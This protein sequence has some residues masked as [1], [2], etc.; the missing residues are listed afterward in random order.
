MATLSSHTLNSTNGTHA[1]GIEVSLR[2][3]NTGGVLFATRM[4]SGGRL[5]E[6]IDISAMSSDDRYE[7]VFLTAA[8]WVEQG[9]SHAHIVDEIV[10]RFTMP[11]PEARYHMPVIL[12]PNGY[13]MWSSIPEYG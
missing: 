4:D 5:A 9:V 11:D 6:T 7:L 2:N 13:S 8:Y 1:G 3:I 10:L 12:S